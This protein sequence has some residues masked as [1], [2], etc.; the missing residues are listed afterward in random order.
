M[1]AERRSKILIVEDE[2]DVRL[3]L[4]TLLEDNDYETVTAADG[5]EGFR[6]LRE[7]RPDLV[8]L[9]LQMP[10]ETGTRFWRRMSR[11]EGL[12]DVPVI[13]ISGVAGR[14]LAV[15]HPVAVLDKPID[16]AALLDAVRAALEPDA[17]H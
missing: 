2:E 5:E 16:R 10:G 13:V 12:A 7:E 1:S 3:F 11:E 8:T 14:H 17:P 15:G 4:K 6:R 9:D